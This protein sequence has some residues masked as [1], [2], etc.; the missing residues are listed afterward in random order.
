MGKWKQSQEER[1]RDAARNDPARVKTIREIADIA[2]EHGKPNL[3]NTMDTVANKKE[4]EYYKGT[5]K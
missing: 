5:K 4:A 2:R 1:E 3:G